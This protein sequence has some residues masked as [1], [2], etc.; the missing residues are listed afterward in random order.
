MV[1][2]T[3]FGQE[4]PDLF[5]CRS[6]HPSVHDLVIR[7]IYELFARKYQFDPKDEAAL[8]QWDTSE[9]NRFWHYFFLALNV[10]MGVGGTFTLLV[11]GIGVANIMYIVVRERTSEIG[12]KMA[13]GA[14]PRVIMA[15]VLMQAIALTLIGGALGLILSCAVIAAVSRMPFTDAFLGVPTIAPWAAG[16]TVFLLGTVGFGA[17]FF[18][19]RRAAHMDPVQALGY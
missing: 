11:G 10:L 6:I 8:T 14:K 5:I 13:V 2:V 19:A 3:M 7:R 17:G 9:T 16:L 12:I 18:P 1:R 4:Q 15:Q